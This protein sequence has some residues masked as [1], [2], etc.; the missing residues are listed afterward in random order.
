MP[1]NMLRKIKQLNRNN[2][3]NTGLLLYDEIRIF[4]VKQMAYW[5][6]HDTLEDKAARR[7]AVI[8]SKVN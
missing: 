2:A 4:G 3:S 6:G 8:D 5:W 7:Q 1:Q